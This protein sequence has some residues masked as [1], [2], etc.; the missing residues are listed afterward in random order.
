MEEGTGIMEKNHPDWKYM[1]WTD[2]ANTTLLRNYYPWFLDTYNSYPHHIQR[3]DAIRPFILYH[4]GGL[5]VDMDTICLRNFDSV[6]KERGVYIVESG[7][8]GCSNSMMGSSKNHVFWRKM[9]DLLLLNS[10]RK[11]YQ[12]HYLYIMQSTGPVLLTECVDYYKKNKLNNDLFIIPKRLFNP[13]NQCNKK[14][15]VSEEMYSYTLNAS[16]WHHID[17]TIIQYIYCYR[18]LLLF[19]LVMIFLLFL[20]KDSIHVLFKN[21]R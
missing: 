12:V 9:M 17:S 13:C 3:A 11:F 7:H 19:V 6:F 15:D 10:K 14:C 1:L 2:V 21:S 5:Y 18:R 8:F 20:N 16:T 4:Y